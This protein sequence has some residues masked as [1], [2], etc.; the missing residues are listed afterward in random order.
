M[1]WSQHA[2]WWHVYP[3]GFT[4][5]PV[6][7]GEGQ[8]GLTHRLG[9]L[10]HWLEYVI[11][12]GCNGLL[13]GPVFESETHGYDTL[14]HFR[15]DPRLGDDSDFDHL[16]AACH[17]RGIKVVLDGVFNHV[18]RN[19]PSFLSAANGGPESELFKI[20]P[21]GEVANF[22]GHDSLVELNHSSAAAEDLVV[23]VMLHWLR[24]GISGWRLDAAYAVEPAFWKRVLP[25]VRAEFPDA[26][27]LG[28]VIHGDYPAIVAETGMDSVTQ[29]E[30]WKAIWSSLTDNNLFELEWSLRRHNDFLGSFVPQTFVGNHDVTRIATLLDSARTALAHVVL[31]TV[32]G[33]PS[34]YYGDEQAYTG[35]K[36]ERLGG[37]DDIRPP[38]PESPDE[39]S[40][41]GEWAHRLLTDLISLRR[42]NSW[43]TTARTE[44]VELSNTVLAY[45]VVGAEGQR[46]RVELSLEG[47][48]GARILSEG[49][50]LLEITV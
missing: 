50:T 4:G 10:E 44:T 17:E 14:D 25:R 32:G 31:F 2:I 18:G 40:P 12:L 43:L 15:I 13:L 33:I 19:H 6:R 7:P 20:S 47:T 49:Q 35:S 36:T 21:S 45:D 26:W 1:S 30:L 38:F 8:R 23:D 37:D 16:V 29:Y 24:R 48:P 39:L 9:R 11:E 42:R 27:I 34:V 46:L 28:E 3:L 5:A 41:L 22:E